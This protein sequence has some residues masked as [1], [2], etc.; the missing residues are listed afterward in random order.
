MFR[1]QFID[2]LSLEF[3]IVYTHAIRAKTGIL[4]VTSQRGGTKQEKE[5]VP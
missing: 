5:V 3:N 1:S 2:A 4:I